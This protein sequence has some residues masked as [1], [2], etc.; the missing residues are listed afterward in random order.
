M[1]DLWRFLSGDVPGGFAML[2]VA[3]IAFLAVWIYVY[4]SGETLK[5]PSFR[6][7][8]WRIPLLFLLIYFI[9]WIQS[10]PKRPPLRLAVVAGETVGGQE[11][12][13]Q[14]VADLTARR[15]RRALKGA[16][17]NSWEGAK[18]YPAP[19]AEV[20]EKAGYHVFQIR[21]NSPPG[22]KALQYSISGRSGAERT[23]AATEHALVELSAQMH[24]W[25]LTELGKKPAI[26][27]AFYRNVSLETLEDYYRGRQAFGE[28]RMDSALIAFDAV[29]RSDSAF[30]PAGLYRG[31]AHEAKGERELA[32]AAYLQAAQA[33]T[34]SFEA[35]L[36]LGEYY[37]RIF[38]WETAEAALKI[39]LARNPTSARAAAGLARIHPERLKDLRLNSPEKL[40]EEALRLDPAYESA[41]LA[42]ADRLA[43]R[44]FP[45]AAKRRLNEGLN[46]D[47]GSIDL[48]L[49]LG[50][51][52][53]QLGRP[54]AARAIYETILTNDPLNAIALFN[55]GVVDYRT[56]QYDQAIERF[57]AVQGLH[58]PVDCYYYLGLI[59]Q[60]KGDLA[61]AKFYFQK[62]WD[63][64]T[65]D[66]DAF[67]V[68]ARDTAAKL[69]DGSHE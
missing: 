20:L 15:L 2:L 44:G 64:R 4:R 17:V 11:W 36:G 46:L 21:C 27:P 67:A 61:R 40:L 18:D 22:G 25:I 34:G 12:A 43:D 14:G 6:R 63:L 55:L 69:E 7:W 32:L 19:S 37:L 26:T 10:P 3:V 33:D 42:L 57:E 5:L 59:Y 38:D 53:I 39:V 28:G 51:V 8:L 54:E 49:K 60:S 50:A 29:R 35:M 9:A 31:R 45:E 68:K 23:F 48:T 30:W 52:E 13:C 16:V 66:A 56:K 41:R 1:L 62:R 24:N 58:G 47:P 65:S